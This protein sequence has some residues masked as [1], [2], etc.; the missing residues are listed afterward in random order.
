M[1]ITSIDK[2][3]LKWRW[4]DEKYCLLSKDELSQITPLAPSSAKEVWEASLTFAS[5]ESDFSPNKELFTQIKSIE[6]IDD[7]E[8]RKWLSDKL[9]RCEIIVS[10]QE[11]MAVLTNTDLF[12]QYWDDFCYGAS[13]DVSVWPRDQSWVIHYFHEEVFWYGKSASV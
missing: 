3:P 8:V 5:G 6:A 13:D 9:P 12:I 7:K 11:D 1:Q 10:W 4:T 2:F